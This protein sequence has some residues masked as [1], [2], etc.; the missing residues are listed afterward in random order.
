MKRAYDSPANAVQMTPQQ[1]GKSMLPFKKIVFPVDYSDRCQAV[2]PYVQEAVSR[3]SAQ[4]TLVNAYDSA[5]TS[6]PELVAAEPHWPEQ[7]KQRAQAQLHEYAAKAFPSQ[8]AD[9]VC[10]DGEA[11]AVIDDV[12]R[13]QAADLVMLPT[14]GRGPVRKL[15]LGSVT[16]KV[17]HDIS[18]A[19]WTDN[20]HRKAADPQGA[21]YTN[22]ICAIDFT[23]E[24]EAVARAGV[25]LAKTYNARLTLLHVVEIP[26]P[27]MEVDLT[28]YYEQLLDN[29][30]SGFRDLKAKLGIDAP[31][32]AVEGIPAI[33]VCD[34]AAQ[35]G[36]DLIVV[37][38]GREQGGWSRMWSRL[39]AIVREAPCP[40]L[41]I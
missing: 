10:K 28:P 41:S 4:L 20:G 11:S 7:V 34:E 26:P 17:L 38:R 21:A 9:T 16:A 18:A 40:V 14:H 8:R 5:L 24:S 3:F 22:I 39:Y 6:N 33:R 23:E 27:A 25:A 19:V 35:R 37:G 29:A 12:V 1:K 30:N 15:L 2:V 31:H 32:A 13:H 36:A